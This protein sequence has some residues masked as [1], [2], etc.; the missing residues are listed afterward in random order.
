[1][2]SLSKSVVVVD[3]WVGVHDYQDVFFRVGANVDPRRDVVLTDGPLD[4]LDHAPSM[5]FYGGKLGID[6]THKSPAEGARPWPEEIVMSDEI[7]A[8]VD[9]RWGE[10]GIDLDATANGARRGPLRHLL[11]R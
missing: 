7:R 1:M 5:Q 4:H 11:R 8:R 6:A 2:L 10:Y 9:S 3:E